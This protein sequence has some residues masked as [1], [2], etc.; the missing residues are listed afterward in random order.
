MPAA[1]QEAGSQAWSL[2]NALIVLSVVTL[3]TAFVS[4][5]RPLARPLRPRGR[6]PDQF[7]IAVVIVAIV[8]NAA[9]HGGAV[10]IAH[11]WEHDARDGDRDHLVDAG[12]AVRRARGRAPLLALRPAAC[13]LSFKVVE[14]ATMG[15]AAAL[16]VRVVWD[17]RSRRWEGYL[18]VGAYAL[19][20]LWYALA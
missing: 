1:D 10:V 8:G 3:A 2:R 9:E 7:F 16:A 17:G 20:V 14:I 4:R 6:T 5:A 18:L 15:L 12:G 13:P 19:C 11:S